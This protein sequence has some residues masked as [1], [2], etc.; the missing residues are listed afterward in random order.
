MRQEIKIKLLQNMLEEVTKKY[1]YFILKQEQMLKQTYDLATRDPLTGLYNRQYLQDYV[2]QA[3]DRMKRHNIKLILIFIDLDNFKYVNDTFGHEDGDRVLK[4]VSKIFQDSFRKY[5]VVVR[6]G[7]D[8]FIIFLEEH[9]YDE[10]FIRDILDKM[11]ARIEERLKDFSISASYG[12]AIAPT[13]TQTFKELLSLA[14]ERM[15]EHKR[16]K[17]AKR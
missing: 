9:Q 8:E 11:V 7:G 14:D 15:Y 10:A 17:K 3:L 4:E 12:C 1:D 2:S 13:E 6:Y 16:A 5:D